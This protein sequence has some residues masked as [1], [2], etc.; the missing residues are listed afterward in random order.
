MIFL[1]LLWAFLTVR[2][3]YPITAWNVMVSADLPRGYSYCILR[4]ETVAGETI[5]I[6]PINL[7]NALYSRTWT[8]VNATITNQALKIKSPHP[9]NAELIRQVGGVEK[10]PAGARIPELLKTWGR[11]Y[12]E[13]LPD[14]SPERLKAI[15]LDWY[16]WDG[17][18][19]S[20]YQEFVDSWH[21]D[22]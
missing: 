3:L 12:N 19:Y 9:Q 14:S 2:S 10:L 18:T 16:R 11:L 5:D 13:R 6:A 20:N 22:L 1:P 8:M 21:Q 4:G 7:T 15:R 17:A